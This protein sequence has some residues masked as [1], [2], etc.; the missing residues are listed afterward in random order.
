[1]I[2]LG[3][4]EI[5]AIYLGSKAISMVYRG[6]VLVWQAVRSCFGSGH[7]VGGKPWIGKEAWKYSKK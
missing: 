5:T 7:W 3:N 6:T 1:M 2:K 4:K